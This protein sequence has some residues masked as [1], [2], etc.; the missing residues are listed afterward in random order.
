MLA[1]AGGHRRASPWPGS[2]PRRRPGAGAGIPL[3]AVPGRD[4]DHDRRTRAG[5]C[6]VAAVCR[7]RCSV[8]R[9][10]SGCAVASRSA[11]LREGERGSTGL[12]NA[13][14]RTL[15]A[16]EVAL[17]IVVLSGSG[18]L[19]KSLSELL[20]VNPGPRSARRPDDAG[21]A[22]AGEHLRRA[23][24]RI[25]LRRSLEKRRGPARHPTDRRDQPPAAERRERRP[26][27]DDRG[28]RADRT[29]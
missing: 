3:A 2:R 15:V 26:G 27:P 7:P 8:S 20:N 17:A 22:A 4:P 5:I 12:A 21:V 25:V 29:R 16:I 14:R 13:A 9:R 1:A 23:G 19:I 10:S 28:L 6:R 18:L 11:L 24:A